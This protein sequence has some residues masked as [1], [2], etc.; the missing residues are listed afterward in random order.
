M[1]RVCAFSLILLAVSSLVS[2]TQAQYLVSGAIN[3]PDANL[4]AAIRD[5][6]EL[7]GDGPI[8]AREMQ[9]LTTLI[10]DGRQIGN[11][12]GLEYA[13]E[14][15]TLTAPGN[16]IR[17]LKPLKGLTN[18]TALHLSA[19][20]I[21]DITPLQGLTNLTTLYISK[22]N[23]TNVSPIAALTNL[24]RLS[25]MNNQVQNV[26]PLVELVNLQRLELKGNPLKN[27][28]WLSVLPETIS[29]DLEIPAV[30]DIPDVNLAAAIRNTLR[31]HPDA[32]I[33]K[34][35]IQ[36]L[37]SL[38]AP[39]H[40][41]SDLTGLEHA[42]GLIILV[43]NNNQISDLSPLQRLTHL[44]GYL[45]LSDNN[46]SDLSPLIRLRNL[47][48]LRIARNNISDLSPLAKL[49]RLKILDL[50]DNQIRDITPLAK[51]DQF[52]ALDLRRNKIR[53]IEPLAE[54][55]IFSVKLDGNPITD[56]EW[57]LVP[58]I[59]RYI[60]IDLPALMSFPDTNLEAVLRE[61]L[62]ISQDSPI[63]VNKV[64]GITTLDAS[65]R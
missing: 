32:P 5:A 37:K 4:A 59:P 54:L 22:N 1:K 14:L 51:I 45:E 58:L 3:V 29:F 20:E 36:R 28:E 7:Y 40:N 46:I 60:D 38:E 34:E 44:Y 35:K 19:N 49:K 2:V 17:S 21:S 63:S 27:A 41:I 10:A 23:I 42:T 52:L 50:A 8:T 25:L 26:L 16:R 43:L 56:A 62:D 53:K 12:T 9:R 11:L 18:L 24:T 30:I 57:L 65:N 6:L 61:A 47:G 39:D 33:A 64:R 48:D 13:T 15:T 31:L 55:K